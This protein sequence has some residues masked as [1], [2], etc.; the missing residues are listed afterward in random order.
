MIRNSQPFPPRPSRRDALRLAGG[1]ALTSVTLAGCDLL[2]TD[3][4]G[5]DA[6]GNA[7]A[8]KGKQAPSLDKLVKS[9]DLPPVA[10]RLPKN[11]LVV[12]PISEIGRYGGT[13]R[14]YI[15]GLAAVGYKFFV[16]LGYDPLVS[17]KPDWSD[18]IPNLAE[19]WDVEN[20]GQAYTFHLRQGVKWSD[21]EP[22]TADDLAFMFENVWGNKELS[23]IPPTMFSSGGKLATFEKIDDFTV[24]V[25]FDAPSALF[26]RRLATPSATSLL[27]PRHYMEKFH[28]DFNS[29]ANAQAKDEGFADWIEYFWNRNTAPSNSDRPSLNAWLLKTAVDESSGRAV[30]ER[31]PYYWKVDP[32]G[33]QLPYIDKVTYEIMDLEVALLRTTSGDLDLNAPALTGGVTTLDNK[34]VLARGRDKGGFE[35]VEGVPGSMNQ[36]VVCLNL[37]HKDPVLREIF[38]NRDFRIGLSHAINREEI[39]NAVYQRQGEPWQAAPRRESEFFT[40]K[41]AKQYTEYDVDLANEHLDR[42]GYSQRDGNGNRLG[43]DGKRIVFSM[44]AVTNEPNQISA[45]ELVRT[46]WGKVGIEMRVKTEDRTLFYDRKAAN[47]HDA[48]V[49]TGDGGLYD[50]DLDPRYYFPYSG[51]SNYAPLWATW[52]TSLGAEGEKPPAAAVEQMKLYDQ[53]AGTVDKAEAGDLFRQVLQI[54]EEQFW[55]IGLVSVDGTYGTVRKNFRNVPK[56]I[57]AA[58]LY[59]A[60]GPTRPEQYYI[61]D[62]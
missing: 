14:S 25:V 13:W 30:W 46:Y 44:E 8:A 19:S 49:W 60:P 28:P 18:V 4:G 23:P 31:N 62:G 58:W 3:P 52:Y 21:G 5:S 40:E 50:A 42:A 17:W 61:A 15:D 12:Q 39:V 57:P 35:F 45:M 59:P 38:Q 20:G 41:L 24:R 22:F 33:S 56:K 11:P 32:D 16:E 1:L 7:G 43:P 48:S 54:A 26:I 9:G 55:V 37:N 10:D 53:Y 29:D 47:L 27:T 51:E 36:G 2:S 34:P 6:G